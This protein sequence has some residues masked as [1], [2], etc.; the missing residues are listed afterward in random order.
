M[1]PR[2][3]FK[4]KKTVLLTSMAV[5][6]GHTMTPVHAA[7]TD[8]ANVPMAVSNMVT[9]NVLVIYDNSQSMDAFMNGTLVSGNDPRTR[10]NIGRTVMR[11]AIGTYRSAFNWGLMTYGM[12][13]AADLFNTYAYYMGSDAGMVFT[14]DCVGFVAGVPPTIGVSATNGN[15]RCIANPQPFPGGNFVTFDKTGD[16]ADIQDVLYWGGVVPGM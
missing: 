9:P 7:S 3:R 13:A 10:S 12:T 5:L 6:F 14:N 8:I 11:N 2:N 15:R 4:H 16:D 1:N